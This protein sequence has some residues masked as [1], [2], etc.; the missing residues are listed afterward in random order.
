LLPETAITRTAKELTMKT[1]YSATRR[2]F[3]KAGGILIAAS[4]IDATARVFA[5]EEE[6]KDNE[7]S[8]PEDLMREHGGLK[9]ILPV[10]GEALRAWPTPLKQGA[11]RKRSARLSMRGHKTLLAYSAAKAS[12]IAGLLA[13]ARRCNELA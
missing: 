7:V 6:K 8:V 5:K 9:R 1:G 12:T 11:T 2:K 4:A 13:A 10:Y 3:I